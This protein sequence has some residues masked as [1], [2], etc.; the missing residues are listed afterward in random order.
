M[1][2]FC[3]YTENLGHPT[4][5]LPTCLSGWT[6]INETCLI[7][8]NSKQNWDNA[9]KNCTNRDSRLVKIDSLEKN[10]FIFQLVK[11]NDPGIGSIWLG[12]RQFHNR[13]YKWSDGATANFTRWADGEP[14]KGD[15]A[16]IMWLTSG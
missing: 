4:A 3:N 13:N 1:F 5:V 7:L 2:C 16:V 10:D 11:T 6:L 12:L 8:V 9:H 15:P 14:N